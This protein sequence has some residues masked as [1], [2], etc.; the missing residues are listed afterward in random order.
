MFYIAP[1]TNSTPLRVLICGGGIAGP[2]LAYWLTRIPHGPGFDITIL[3]RSPNARTTGQAVDIRGPAVKV[4]QRM[5][6]EAEVR[7]RHTSEKGSRRSRINRA[8]AC[9]HS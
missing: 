2:A 6:L 9:S 3:E 4:L 7:R 8:A 5:N 1:M